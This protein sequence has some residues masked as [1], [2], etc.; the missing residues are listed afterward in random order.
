MRSV[1]R[2]VVLSVA[3]LLSSISG[4]S[5]GDGKRIVHLDLKPISMAPVATLID[6][7]RRAYVQMADGDVFI[8]PMLFERSN[9]RIVLESRS[10]IDCYLR[11]FEI[12][13]DPPTS[14]R[15][16]YSDERALLADLKEP[17]ALENLRSVTCFVP[18]GIKRGTTFKLRL[19]IED[20]HAMATI[21]LL[22]EESTA[23]VHSPRWLRGG[24]EV[25]AATLRR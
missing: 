2:I 9:L 18:S 5:L 20:G 1:L 10:C 15:Y 17:W 3:T 19:T 11:S 4:C 23:I 25:S 7:R 16:L 8:T 21:E 13:L 14:C 6:N 24:S 22:A 12:T